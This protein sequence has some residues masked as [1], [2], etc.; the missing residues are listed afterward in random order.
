MN[1]FLL[2]YQL[3][4]GLRGHIFGIEALMRWQHPKRGLV[5]PNDFIAQAEESGLILP[6]GK[7][8][9]EIA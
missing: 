2:Y 5:L 8:A 7:W 1:D 6:L 9:L 3:Q 4:V